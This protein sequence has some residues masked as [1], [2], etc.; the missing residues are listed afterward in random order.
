MT[1]REKAPRGRPRPADAIERDDKIL[2]LLSEF[3]PQTRNAIANRL[4]ISFS[5]TYLALDRLRRAGRVK[6]C[7]QGDGGSVWST[8][9]D[10]SC[11]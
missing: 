3:G 5:L 11:P 10:E 6:R 1:E 4:G 8:A 7:L 2:K 9:V